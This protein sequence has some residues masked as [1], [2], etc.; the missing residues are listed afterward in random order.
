MEGAQLLSVPSTD[1]WQQGNS[2]STFLMDAVGI[3]A[4]QRQSS[5]GADFSSSPVALLSH[6]PSMVGGSDVQH[7]KTTTGMPGGGQVFGPLC[8]RSVFPPCLTDPGLWLKLQS[9]ERLSAGYCCP[10]GGCQVLRSSWQRWRL[11]GRQFG[12]SRLCSRVWCG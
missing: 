7:L 6:T 2:G 10:P 8:F 4:D 5:G 11:Q 3:R 9:P 1:L 12:C